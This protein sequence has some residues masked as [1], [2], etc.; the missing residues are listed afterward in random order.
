MLDYGRRSIAVWW[1]AR[2]GKSCGNG[3]SCWRTA[4]RRHRGIAFQP[5]R[6]RMPGW[7]PIPG[8]GQDVLCDTVCLRP[9][10]PPRRAL[11]DLYNQGVQRRIVLCTTRSTG[12]GQGADDAVQALREID[13][14][15]MMASIITRRQAN[16]GSITWRCRGQLW[17]RRGTR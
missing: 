11:R 8:A 12:A 17:D 14:P 4:W 7:K 13:V 15:E 3:W 9:G 10:P 16:P 5:V 1:T 6:L 2:H